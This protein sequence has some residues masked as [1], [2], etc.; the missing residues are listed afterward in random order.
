MEFRFEGFY[1][2]AARGRSGI[3]LMGMLPADFLFPIVLFFTLGIHGT[4]NLAAYTQRQQDSRR[5]Q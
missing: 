4:Q 2:L 1:S 3:S 5:Y